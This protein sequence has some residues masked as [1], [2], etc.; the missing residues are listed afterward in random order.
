MR[1]VNKQTLLWVGIGVAA[2]YLFDRMLRKRQSDNPSNTGGGGGL[3]N[4]QSVVGRT[5]LAISDDTK[6]RSSARV[7]NGGINNIVGVLKKD[8]LAGTIKG[9]A[10]GDDGKTWYSVYR[11]LNYQCPFMQCG[12]TGWHS[13]G[14]VR[15]DVVKVI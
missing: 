4:P 8:E 9:V 13:S 5:A 1:Q 12:F 2:I 7:N 3:P 6:V 11:T 14:F 15:S 10:T